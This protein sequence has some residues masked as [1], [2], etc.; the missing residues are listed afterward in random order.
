MRARAALGL[1]L[2]LPACGTAAG[3]AP[4]PVWRVSAVQAADMLLPEAVEDATCR[5][6]LRLSV[7]GDRLRLRLSH[8]SGEQPLTLSA[9]TV[10]VAG[11]GAALRPATV[12][13]VTVA[14]SAEVVVPAG[15]AVDTDPVALPTAAGDRLA[16]SLAVPGPE[17]LSAHRIGAEHAWCSADG[18]GDLTGQVAATGFGTARRESPVLEAVTVQGAA[19]PAAVLAVGDSLTDAPLP[20]GSRSR[21]TDVLAARLPGTPVVSAAVAGSRVRLEGGLGRP[22][23]ERF[24]RD[25]LSREG[26]GTVVLLAGT[27]DLARD[28]PAQQLVADLAAL[29]DRARAAGLRVVLATLPPARDR[30]AAQTAA[31]HEVNAWVRSA[32]AFVDADAVLRDPADPER[33]RPAY[34]ADGL[35]LTAAGQRA[36]G[37]A[38]AD[39][40]GG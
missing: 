28:L 11:G 16:V 22:L 5:A 27:N 30:T 2:L 6:V 26:V 23:R 4:A 36:L 38:V 8:A 1:L 33:L 10:A 14:G 20:P 29:A 31:R 34:D 21:W 25:V 9:V 15:G 7:G 35:H 39:A 32:E 13:P 40:L 17:R 18:R 24:D 37:E 12:R 19:G 3:S